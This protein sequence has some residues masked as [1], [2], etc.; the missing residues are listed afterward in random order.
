MRATRV[1]GCM[2]P[3]SKSRSDN[4]PFFHKT[5]DGRHHAG[6]GRLQ[7]RERQT[8]QGHWQPET[9]HGHARTQALRRAKPVINAGLLRSFASPGIKTPASHW[10]S[11]WRRTRLKHHLHKFSRV[12]S[13]DLHLRAEVT[14]HPL[15]VASLMS[16]SNFP[17]KGSL[18]TLEAKTCA[19]VI[20][21]G[22]FSAVASPRTLLGPRIGTP[23]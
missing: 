20:S 15:I 19:S 21:T 3:P 17:R 16:A 23:G 4:A 10:W 1:C 18:Y 6:P 12:G 5:V 11:L 9:P 13:G 14:Q 2:E 7:G 8:K 22:T